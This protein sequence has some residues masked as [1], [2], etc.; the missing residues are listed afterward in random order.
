MATKYRPYL[1]PQELETILSSL[2]QTGS[3]PTLIHYLSG[4]Q[5]KIDLG[6]TKPNM[7]TKPTMEESLGLGPVPAIPTTVTRESAY[8]KWTINPQSCTPNEIDMSNIYRYENNLMSPE[9]ESTYESQ[10]SGF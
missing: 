9:E 10:M 7:V 5:S 2:K 4:F 6:L 3:N 1:T 8:K